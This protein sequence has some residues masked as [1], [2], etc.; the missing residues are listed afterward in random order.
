MASRSAASSSGIFAFRFGDLGA[1]ILGGDSI[2]ARHRRADL[3][4]GG[5]AALLGALQRQDRR[6]A[7]FVERDQQFG[8]R[9]QPAPPQTLVK[10]IRIIANCFDIV[11]E[12]PKYFRPKPRPIPHGLSKD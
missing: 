4:R 9:R 5:V 6:P 2:L 8:A 10:S 7:H 12:H 1:K 11:H 3:L